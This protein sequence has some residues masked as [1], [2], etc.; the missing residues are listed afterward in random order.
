MKLNGTNSGDIHV[1]RD[2]DYKYCN[3][4][5]NKKKHVFDFNPFYLYGTAGHYSPV[6][7]IFGF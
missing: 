1:K 7:P 5:V 3:I 6:P 4:V 2:T